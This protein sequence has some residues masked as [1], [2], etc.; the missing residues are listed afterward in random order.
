M[1]TPAEDVFPAPTRIPVTDDRFR[2]FMARH[3]AF[4]RGE[5]QH[6]VLRA[7][8]VFRPSEAVGLRQPDGRV[9]VETEHLTPDMVDPNA[10]IDGVE[11]WDAAWPDARLSAFSQVLIGLGM[12]DLMPFSRPPAKI[13]WIEAMLGCPIVMTEGQIWT[14]PYPGD[15]E[16][17]IRRGVHL[18]QDPWFQLFLEFLRLLQTRLADRYPPCLN[19]LLRGTS[20][21]AAALLGVQGACVGFLDRPAFMARL[22]RVCTDANLAVIEAGYKVLQPFEN[23]TMSGFGVW[24]PGQVVLTQADHSALISPHMYGRQ[25]LPYDLEVIRSCPISMFHVHNCALHIAP[26]LIEIPELDVI[27][28]RVNPYP[29]AER[30]RYE[31]EMMQRIQQ[32]KLLIVDANFPTP[33]EAEAVLAELSPRGLC[34]RT[35]F[36][37]PVYRSLPP[38]WPGNVSWT[39]AAPA[40]AP[41]ARADSRTG[42]CL[43]E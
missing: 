15:P 7:A 36:E 28:V 40:H 38:D 20:D 2:S 4:W 42:R 33:E 11:G 35:W 22:L 24:S 37:L 14:G 27:Q 41:A 29:T 26:L 12:G 43:H 18:E 23:G 13:P 25:I 17:V 3:R 19:T 8:G 21:L 39:L 9:I 16:E 1:P 10:L 31:I 32:H 34:F 6:G 5:G 30:R